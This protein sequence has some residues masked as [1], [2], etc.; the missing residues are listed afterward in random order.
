MS[1]NVRFLAMSMWLLAVAGMVAVLAMK[2]SG[3]RPAVSP[4]S[5]VIAVAQSDSPPVF[6]IHVPDFSLTDQLGQTVTPQQLLGQPWIA[7]FIFTECASECPIMT[8]RLSSLQHTI[9]PQVKFV[10]F[11]VDPQRDTPPVLLAY[12]RQYGA[13]NDRWL[14]LTGQPK[15]VL[16]TIAGM[17]VTFVPADKDNPIGHDIH[18]LLIDSQGRMRGAYDSLQPGEVARLV[19]DANSLA[20]ENQP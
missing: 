18:Y 11:T 7:D 20:A 16:A 10:S 12:A 19:Q 5:D 2:L 17:K 3:D 13:D 14:F 1:R 4:G 8:K 15:D 6:P 9:P